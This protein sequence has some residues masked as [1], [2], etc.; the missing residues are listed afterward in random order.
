MEQLLKAKAAVYAGIA[1]LEGHC[2]RPADRL[3]LAGGFA[4][5]LDRANAVAIGM[6]PDR[7]SAIVGNTSLAGAARVACDPETLAR[8]EALIDLPVELPLNTLPGFEDNFIDGLLLPE[9]VGCESS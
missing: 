8:L 4:K 9:P 6:L 3:F 7:P 5:Y 2:G 1:T